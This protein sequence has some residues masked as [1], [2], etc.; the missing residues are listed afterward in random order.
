MGTEQTGVCAEAELLSAYI[1]GETS[2]AETRRVQEHLLLCP[3]C[4]SQLAFLR[5]LN[6]G[7]HSAPLAPPS[8]A[9][10]DRIASAT[11][12][13]PPSKSRVFWDG[14]RDRV[15]ALLAPPA[16]RVGFGTALAA[17]VVAAF[18]LPRLHEQTPQT[19]AGATPAPTKATVPTPTFNPAAPRVVVVPT[20]PRISPVRPQVGRGETGTPR[21]TN[22][23]RISGLATT[24]APL[25][26]RIVPSRVQ[27]TGPTFIPS[28]KE[29][30]RVATG[31]TL[32]AVSPVPK[33]VPPSVRPVAG[34][35]PATSPAVAKPERRIA[36]TSIGTH[37][38]RAATSPS[39]SRP[40]SALTPK[41]VS[42]APVL[43]SAS[44]STPTVVEPKPAAPRE[45]ERVAVA[46]RPEVDPESAAP[47]EPIV[48]ASFNKGGFRLKNTSGRA[49][50]TVNAMTLAS[51]QQSTN[52]SGQNPNLQNTNIMKVVDASVR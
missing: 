31:D 3:E 48:T 15:A 24:I 30:S 46:S 40:A 20:T 14:L 26:P 16:V 39:T 36:S 37:P 35:H 42:P 52:F 22:T 41:E 43:A 7:L 27:D 47:S 9:L 13:T 51:M 4:A 1:D 23:P 17:G 50:S 5:A 32:P 10:F 33:T 11:Y 6:V 25:A 19:I 8:P 38:T 49:G 34:R 44:P 12:A 21:T 28:V 29:A 2:E 45:P 18:V